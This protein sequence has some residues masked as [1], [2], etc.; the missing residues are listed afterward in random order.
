MG[1]KPTVCSVCHQP[2]P[3]CQIVNGVCATCRAAAAQQKTV[4][5]TASTVTRPMTHFDKK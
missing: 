3:A 5:G 4:A 1:C 2:K